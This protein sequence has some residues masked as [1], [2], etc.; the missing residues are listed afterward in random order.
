MN[1]TSIRAPVGSYDDAKYNWGLW[2]PHG[3]SV[4]PSHIQL[5]LSVDSGYSVLCCSVPQRAKMRTQ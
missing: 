2:G 1:A 3:P 5:H 4:L